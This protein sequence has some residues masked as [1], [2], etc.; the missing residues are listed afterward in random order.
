MTRRSQRR[1]RAQVCDSLV[2]LSN[3]QTRF[4]SSFCSS[5]ADSSTSLWID[6]EVLTLGDSSTTKAYSDDVTVPFVVDRVNSPMFGK[7]L[8]VKSKSFQLV[9]TAT[10]FVDTGGPSVRKLCV[11]FFVMM[12]FLLVSSRHDVHCSNESHPHAEARVGHNGSVVLF[13]ALCDALSSLHLCFHSV[14]VLSAV[15]RCLWLSDLR[16]H[17]Y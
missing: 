16:I 5:A 6:S 12:L 2:R 11:L 9:S 10:F 8:T 3:P 15:D 13:N 17:Q 4:S 7:N 1:S 14:G